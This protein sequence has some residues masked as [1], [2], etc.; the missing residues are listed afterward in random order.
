[1]REKHCWLAKNKRLKAQANRPNNSLF[2]KQISE[3][4]IGMTWTGRSLNGGSFASNC[5]P[6]CR[7]VFDCDSEARGPEPDPEISP[8]RT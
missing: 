2:G 3:T 7:I 8:D 4:I 6:H 5:L 1:M